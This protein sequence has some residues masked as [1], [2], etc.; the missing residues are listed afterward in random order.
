MDTY[1]NVPVEEYRFEVPG[2]QCQAPFLVQHNNKLIRVIHT[3]PEQEVFFVKYHDE[4][5]K[6]VRDSSNTI[7]F[8]ES[9]SPRSQ[10]QTPPGYRAEF[11]SEVVDEE[12]AAEEEGDDYGSDIEEEEEKPREDG[13]WREYF[14]KKMREAEE[15]RKIPDEEFWRRRNDQIA[16]M[17]GKA[18]AAQG[19]SGSVPHS[20]E[21]TLK[22][23]SLS[24]WNSW[25]LKLG[26]DRDICL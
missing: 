17:F 15:T 23:L 11:E 3:V 18:F 20:P 7:M 26:F 10:P 14:E 22:S 12:D 4:V 21:P 19:N 5:F 6:V 25:I 24:D 13:Y 2:Y 8:P 1:C 9:E 16:A